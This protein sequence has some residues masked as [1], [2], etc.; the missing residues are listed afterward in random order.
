MAGA[1]GEATAAA[2]PSGGSTQDHVQRLLRTAR[3]QVRM[4][5]AWLSEFVGAEQVFRIVD[6]EPGAVAPLVGARSS[7]AGSVCARVLDG[8]APARIPDTRL[9]P[10]AAL[11]D[12]TRE[13]ALGAYL[14]VP[15][16]ADDGSVAGMVCA[17]SGQAAPDLSE[18]DLDT[19][20]ELARVLHEMH[21]GALPQE[22]LDRRRR[23]L[24]RQVEALVAGEGRSVVV[25][26]V[27][28]ARTGRVVLLEA[29]SRFDSPRTP[30]EWFDVASRIGLGHDLEVAAARSALALL[31]D[32]RLPDSAALS[33]N[34][35]PSTVTSG[36]L[37]GLLDGV[38]LSRVVVELTESAPVRDYVALEVALEPWREQGLRVAVDD[39]G[40]GYASLQHVLM[41]RPDLV[42]LDMSL[43]RGVDQ[44]PVRAALVSALV[45]FARRTGSEVVA[46]GVETAAEGNALVELGVDLLQG[47]LTG[48][49]AHP[50]Q[51]ADA[52]DGRPA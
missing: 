5:V 33:I 4:D 27:R 39:T 12:V 46:E 35:C 1:F 47:Y 25:Q 29:L 19:L 15:L 9:E 7:L 16:L 37:A 13:L 28:S 17:A 22:H 48:R 52:G 11:L 49:P 23:D 50:R 21:V 30:A 32:S 14:G 2:A 10:G 8:R 26:P 18:R 36:A 45:G 24:V 42:K 43:V 6:A 40:A 20:H 41:V 51:F 38:D 31:R 34:L 3:R 44:D